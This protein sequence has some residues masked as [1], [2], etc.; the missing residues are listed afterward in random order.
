MAIVEALEYL[1]EVVAT[2]HIGELCEEHPVVDGLN[3]LKHQAA[4][5]L[6]TDDIE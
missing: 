5:I 1:V 6:L 3:I 4:D 2:I